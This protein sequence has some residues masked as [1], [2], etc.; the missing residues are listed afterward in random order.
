MA[1]KVGDPP[2][3][4]VKPDFTLTP[5]SELLKQPPPIHWL[6]QDYLPPESLCMM[7]G[8]SASGKSL[9]AIDMSACI[10]TGSAWKGRST[11]QGGVVY[12]AG[13]GHYGMRKRLM[14]WAMSN[15]CVEELENARLLVIERR[16]DL[17]IRYHIKPNGQR[18]TDSEVAQLKGHTLP[19]AMAGTLP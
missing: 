8:A 19:R 1:A 16:G 3:R 10:A 6:L 14:A 5:V 9:F 18:F 11:T 17:V 7:Y 2:D 12:P 13:E 15:D 4:E